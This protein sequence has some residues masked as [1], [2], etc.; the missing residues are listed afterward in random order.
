[1]QLTEEKPSRKLYLQKN[2]LQAA[3]ERISWIFSNYKKVKVSVSGGKDSTVLAE[4]FWREAQERGRELHI[5][6]LDQEAEYASTI[7]IVRGIMN[8]PG[9]VPEWWQSPFRLTSSVSYEMP[10]LNCWGEG[11]EWMREKEDIAFKERVPIK[12]HDLVEDAFYH[13][14]E[15]A[16]S[17]CDEDTAIVI[18]LRSEESLNRYGAV[19]RNPAIADIR[20]SSKSVGKAVKFYPLYDW[21]FEDIWT[22]LGTEKV[23]YNRVYDWMYVKGFNIPEL[24]VSNLVSEKAFKSLAT[25]QEFEPDTFEKLVKRLKGV[26]TAALYSREQMVFSNKKLPPAFK[27][28]REY[29]DFLLSTLPH[30]VRSP[31]VERFAH[32][33]ESESIAKQQV[34]Q[35][36]INDWENLI[37]VKQTVEREDPRKKWMELL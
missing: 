19:T 3:Q 27:K 6:F 30:E 12:Q 28:W 18:G 16:E 34:R 25:L 10:F 9:V 8:R 11:E 5:F 13:M 26:H 17:L 36:L 2:V 7:E 22:F 29:R 24:R 31:F 21:T 14:V 37:P 20:W 23:P 15:Y 1:M 35:I 32:Q 33:K 4:L